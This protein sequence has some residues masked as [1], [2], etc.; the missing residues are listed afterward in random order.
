MSCGAPDVSVRAYATGM[1]ETVST[2]A[3]GAATPGTVG[4][5]QH[6]QRTHRAGQ[7]P[8]GTVSVTDVQVSGETKA[9]TP[10]ASAR[11]IANMALRRTRNTPSLYIT[12]PNS[13]YAA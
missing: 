9:I 2:V 12:L 1:T 4:C 8:S 10:E 7:F 11:R 6:P 13:G 3:S 5:A